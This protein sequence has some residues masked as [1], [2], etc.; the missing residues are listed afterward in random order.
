[1]K[2]A[3]F[4]WVGLLL[5]AVARAAQ[6]QSGD[7]PDRVPSGESGPIQTLLEHREEIGLTAE[8]VSGLR[9]V[10]GRV[11]ERNRPLVQRFLEIRRRWERE[12]PANW[13]S[14]PPARRRQIQERFQGRIRAESRALEEQV[15]TN[16][17]AAMLEVRAMLT[18][19]QRQKLRSFLEDG[20]LP[21]SAVAA[22]G[23]EPR[24][25]VPAR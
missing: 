14:L 23:P 15:Q 24:L 6:A 19:A 5:L 17:R 3:I 22:P 18:R 11:S 1:M 10:Q 2:R 25:R 4:L 13:R 20:S 7:F 9:A 8:Q 21:G 12:R 16:H